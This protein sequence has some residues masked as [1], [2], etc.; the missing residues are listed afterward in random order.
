MSVCAVRI[1][2]A[3]NQIT[4]FLVV[5]TRTC[6]KLN[7]MIKYYSDVKER[8]KS[9]TILIMYKKMHGVIV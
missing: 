4:W 2:V 1:A 8:R 7:A 9:M 6:L 3:S 5:T